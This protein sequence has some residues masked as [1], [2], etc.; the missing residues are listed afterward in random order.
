MRGFVRA[1]HRSRK[2]YGH[3]QR[4]RLRIF[5]RWRVSFVWN[6]LCVEHQPRQLWNLVHNLRRPRQ[7]QRQLQRNRL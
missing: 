2:R 1:L 5:L 3:V 7:W 6:H 4:H